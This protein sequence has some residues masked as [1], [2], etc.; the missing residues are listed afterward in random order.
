MRC[1]SRRRLASRN[2]DAQNP[3]PWGTGRPCNGPSPAAQ[4][5]RAVL[6]GR[7]ALAPTA[8]AEPIVVHL[9]GVSNYDLDTEGK[10]R[11]HTLE[12][13]VGF[14]HGRCYGAGASAMRGIPLCGLV[15]TGGCW[16]FQGEAA[17]VSYGA[18]FLVPRYL[19]AVVSMVREVAVACDAGA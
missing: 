7:L 12:N 4:A 16:W 1:L 5:A 10:I 18:G 14:E 13:I 3:P 17:V 15:V 9:D 19:V 8:R 11:K 2:H 6:V